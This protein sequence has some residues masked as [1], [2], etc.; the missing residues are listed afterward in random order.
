[1]LAGCPPREKSGA[2][3]AHAAWMDAKHPGPFTPIGDASLGLNERCTACH[4]FSQLTAITPVGDAHESIH[5]LVSATPRGAMD[6]LFPPE[7]AK[8]TPADPLSVTTAHPGGWLRWHNPARFACTAC[9][10][11]NGQGV[12]YSEAQHDRMIRPM[13]DYGPLTQTMQARCGSCHSGEYV[14]SAPLLSRGR[15]LIREL[16]CAACHEVSPQLAGTKQGPSLARAAEKLAPEVLFHKPNNSSAWMV[17]HQSWIYMQMPQFSLSDESATKITA[18]LQSLVA[19]GNRRVYTQDSLPPPRP[20][21]LELIKAARCGN[22]HSLAEARGGVRDPEEPFFS[23]AEIG[24][25]LVRIHERVSAE[26]IADYLAEPHAWYPETRMPAYSLSRSERQQIADW[27]IATSQSDFGPGDLELPA[28]VSGQLQQPS[29]ELIAAGRTE[30]VGQGCAGCHSTGDEQVP[31]RLVGPSLLGIGN[32]PLSHLPDSAKQFREVNSL[33]DYLHW[34]VYSPELV[35]PGLMPTYSLSHEDRA[36]IVTALLAET[37]AVWP[38]TDKPLP[39]HYTKDLS[40]TAASAAPSP[41][42]PNFHSEFW[43]FPQQPEG[44]G[45]HSNKPGVTLSLAER[46]LHP[47]SCGQCHTQQYQEWKL[48][49]HGLAMSPGVTGQMVEWVSDPAK[50]D[51]YHSCLKCH[52]TLAE[53]SHIRKTPGGQWEDN[54]HYAG[55]ELYVAGLTCMSC[56]V[57]AH[58]RYGCLLY[59]SPSPRD[60]G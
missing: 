43:R 14:P 60:R 51:E 40:S 36:A 58:T 23:T 41:H 44:S 52:A 9:H 28:G 50:Q 1:L 16:N 25:S 22:C 27:L 24:P 12:S 15:S 29:A 17:A 54:P 49:R 30:F 53:Q 47:R 10:G 20:E 19:A 56:H 18:Y 32:K 45:G 21:G 33:T 3:R 7:S 31:A 8:P 37:T 5:G 38:G 59:T 48:S 11:G 34:V 13:T 2:T 55:D 4:Q 26:W 46:D 57:R 39:A 35:G 42:S 6:E